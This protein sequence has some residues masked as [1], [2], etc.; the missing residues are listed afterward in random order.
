MGDRVF[1]CSL[2]RVALSA[3]L[4]SLVLAGSLA[5][6][7][8]AP[9][10]AGRSE[11][12]AARRLYQEAQKRVTAGDSAGALT[13]LGLLIQQFPADLLAPKA[14]LS[15]LELQRG[16]GDEVGV[17]ATLKKLLADYARSPEAAA[18]F[19]IQGEMA[20]EKARSAA[21]YDQARSIFRRVALL[22]GS[23]EYPVLD[24]RVLARLRSAEVGLQL[25]DR[26]GALAEL[27]AAIEDEKPG[28]FRGRAKLLYGRTLLADAQQAAAALQVLQELADEPETP[29][30]EAGKSS[31]ATSSAGERAAARRLIAL[32]HRQV[33]RPKAGQPQWSRV[34][35]YPLSGLTLR[36][37]E[38]VAAADDGRIVVIDRRA[39][40]VVLLGE[41]GELLGQRPL[42]DAG[43][44]AFASAGA[45]YVLAGGQIVLPFDGQSMTFLQ[46]KAGKE[47]PLKGLLAAVRST[48]GD[49]YLLAKGY[50][51]LLNYQS[52]RLGQEILAGQRFDLTDLERDA[53]GRLYLLDAES[54]RIL[55]LGV[56]RRGVET[57]A[58][59]TW[60]KA[61]AL[62]LDAL[63]NFYVL[64]RGNRRIE[65]FDPQGHLSG[66][67]GPVLGGG[68]ELKDPQD[69]AV[70]GS[71]RL[72]LTDRKLPFVVV[73]E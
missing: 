44:P 29:A 45:P 22:F 69:L 63:G 9:S 39:A 62:A 6:T 55:R 23:E 58:Q 70:D 19:V 38:G 35:R 1:V 27:L 32:A 61:A 43:R 20:I 15:M 60:K 68:I 24:A 11:D 26:G 65:I 21:D 28:R 54:K 42:E 41:Q 31:P 52:P 25:G 51:G 57:V 10:A 14:M 18:A 17:E 56:D 72:V 67:A 16:Q 34:A 50:D 5:A 12:P 47:V 13:E 40:L 7:P 66:A 2:L 53:F 59:G 33:V 73:L 48:F 30:G 3:T 64:D 8:A 36:E 46:P 37:P 4:T 71:G 49:W